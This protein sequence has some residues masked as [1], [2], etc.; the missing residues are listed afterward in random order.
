[1]LGLAA[2]VYI[3]QTQTITDY[4]LETNLIKVRLS[5][6]LIIRYLDGKQL[7]HILVVCLLA[8]LDAHHHYSAL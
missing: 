8:L 3:I 2:L 5:Y 1:V 7:L 4:P 6:R